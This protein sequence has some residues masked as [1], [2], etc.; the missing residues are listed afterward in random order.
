MRA[1]CIQLG[2]DLC[3]MD[4]LNGLHPTE[5]QTNMNADTPYSVQR[6]VLYCKKTNTHTHTLMSRTSC[7]VHRT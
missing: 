6:P 4:P 5:M 2:C 3:V 7:T 1:R